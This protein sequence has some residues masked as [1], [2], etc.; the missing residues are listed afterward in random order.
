[1]AFLVRCPDSRCRSVKRIDPPPHDAR[2]EITLGPPVFQCTPCGLWFHAFE[3]RRP[4]E[5]GTAVEP[6]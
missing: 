3:P 1:M 5:F 6:W 4:G 2:K